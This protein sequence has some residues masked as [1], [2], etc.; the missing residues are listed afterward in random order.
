M[1]HLLRDIAELRRHIK[2]IQKEILVPNNL[3]AFKVWIRAHRCETKALE[4]QLRGDD[5]SAFF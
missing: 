1:P 4:A 2:Q 3:A 5:E